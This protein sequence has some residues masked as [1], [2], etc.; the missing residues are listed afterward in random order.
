VRAPGRSRES[1]LYTRLARRIGAALL[2][3]VSLATSI[4]VT[5]PVAPDPATAL[6][7]LPPVPAVAGGM[8]L[9]HTHTMMTI[10]P[11]HPR[12]TIVKT[13]PKPPVV[14]TPTAVSRSATR[15]VTAT[16]R[17]DVV[18]AFARAQV[19]KPY[20]WGAAGPGSYDC[21]GLVLASYAR[22]G[23]RLPHYTGSMLSY[24][25]SVTR[26]QLR[27][28]DLIWPYPGH[29]VLYLG[30]GR[31]IESPQPGQVVHVTTIYAF[32]TARRLIG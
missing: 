4:S 1:T 10:G 2:V 17:V 12:V 30:G 9:V 21:S 19:G 32:W 23:I 22:V 26:A 29:V 13:T 6:A 8:F 7:D 5:Q 28:G 31:I 3:A 15:T 11:V 16:G 20:V 27:P 18:L 24:G 25:R 14:R